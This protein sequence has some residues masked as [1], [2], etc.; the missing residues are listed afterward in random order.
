MPEPT[1]VRARLELGPIQLGFESMIP[2]YMANRQEEMKAA[3]EKA[4]AEF[5]FQGELKALAKI[6]IRKSM[7]K[8]V[9]D[10]FGY[11]GPAA[12]H[13]EA[14]TLAILE[15]QVRARKAKK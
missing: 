5:D 13:F 4:F 3:L 2:E 8:F 6:A 14:L 12:K 9:E 15:D 7:D 11:D 1:I 10:L